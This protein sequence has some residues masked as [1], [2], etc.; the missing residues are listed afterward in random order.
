MHISGFSIFASVWALLNLAII[1][2][3]IGGFVFL[4]V[5]V[6]SIDKTLKELVEKMD[7][8]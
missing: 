8:D 2:L 4:L 6:N 3:S 1:A 7:R 5:K